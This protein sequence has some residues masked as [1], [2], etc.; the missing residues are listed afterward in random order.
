MRCN[1]CGAEIESGRESSMR[2][3]E[4]QGP[5]RTVT[6]VLGRILLGVFSA[7]WVVTAAISEFWHIKYITEIHKFDFSQQTPSFF[8]TLDTDYRYQ[9]ASYFMVSCLWLIM[10][11]FAWA[12]KLAAHVE[13]SKA[14]AEALRSRSPVN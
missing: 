4:R 11:L 10:V 13:R 8:L 14:F 9:S 12:W 7:G 1:H 2:S 5:R 3:E 6:R